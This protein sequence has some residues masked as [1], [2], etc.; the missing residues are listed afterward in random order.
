MRAAYPLAASAAGGAALMVAYALFCGIGPI[1]GIPVTVV[2]LVNIGFAASY[3]RSFSMPETYNDEH[4]ADG[5]AVPWR[6]GRG[7]VRWQPQRPDGR[8]PWLRDERYYPTDLGWYAAIED[9]EGAFGPLLFRSR[10]Q[11]ERMAKRT[12]NAKLK[13]ELNQ[14]T[15]VQS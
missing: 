13:R 15:E 4:S 9:Y 11:A 14:V 10:W 5:W 7:R 2:G 6:D 3:L 8:R 1:A 12:W